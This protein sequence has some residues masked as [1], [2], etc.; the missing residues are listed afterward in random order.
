MGAGELHCTL[1]EIIL[2][3]LVVALWQLFTVCLMR[4]TSSLTEVCNLQVVFLDL[5]RSLRHS[6]LFF[7]CPGLHLQGHA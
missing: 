5:L 2:S 3:N 7:P 1:P 4:A 6:S